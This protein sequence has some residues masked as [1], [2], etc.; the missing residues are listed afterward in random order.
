MVGGSIG[1]TQE[2][3]RRK[4]RMEEGRGGKMKREDR[5]GMRTQKQ[6]IYNLSKC[7]LSLQIVYFCAR[8][9]SINNAS[10]IEKERRREKGGVKASEGAIKGRRNEGRAKRIRYV[11]RR[12]RDG[13]GESQREAGNE[14]QDRVLNWCLLAI[15]QPRD[16][17]RGKWRE[18]TTEKKCKLGSGV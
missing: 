1:G 10:E 5:A 2:E 12:S 7:L 4:R 3:Y 6:S 16:G 9:W 18:T 14:R 13:R 11:K 17:G 8:H 15:E